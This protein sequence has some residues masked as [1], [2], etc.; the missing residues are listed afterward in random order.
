MICVTTPSY[1]ICL[2]GERHGFF[3]GGRGLR[4]GDPL[5]PYLFTLVMEIVLCHGDVNSVSVIKNALD[6]FSSVSGLCHNLGK[7]TIFCGSMDKATIDA[8]LHILPFKKRKLPVRYL[9]IPPVSK[10]ISVKDCKVYWA[11]VFKLPKVVIDGIEKIFKG[12]LWNKGELQKGKAKVTWKE[13]C[14]PKQNEGLGLK[15]LESWNYALLVKHLW[16]V[17][18]KRTLYG[19][20]GSMIRSNLIYKIGSGKNVLVWHDKWSDNPTLDLIV[21]RR[22]IYSAGFSNTETVSGCISENK[23]RWP[24]EWMVKYPILQTFLIPMIKNDA[25]DKLVWRTNKGTL[26]PF[27]TKQAWKDIRTLNGHV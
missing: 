15:P 25:E 26:K 17:A 7:S 3:K 24:S 8:I 20:N 9:G 23:W 16:N 5:S 12:F 2:N 13:V 18:N 19:S 6:K 11:Y 21:S 14:Q 27:S 1:S 10:K 22:E 4:K